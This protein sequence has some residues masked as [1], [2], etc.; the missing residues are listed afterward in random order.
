MDRS[1][2][3]FQPLSKDERRR[4]L[5]LL[6]KDQEEEALRQSLLMAHHQLDQEGHRQ[7]SRGEPQP[8]P[9]GEQAKQLAE[10]GSMNRHQRVVVLIGLGL[11]TVASLFPPWSFVV[12]YPVGPIPH[13][14]GYSLIF[15]PPT[16]AQS[17]YYAPDRELV[18]VRVDIRTLTIEWAAIALLCAAVVFLVAGRQPRDGGGVN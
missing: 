12:H 11:L 7:E 9:Q 16:Y 14:A 5:D 4:L 2:K 17:G 3:P 13:P 18:E 8:L 6:K 1:P 10:R 15:I